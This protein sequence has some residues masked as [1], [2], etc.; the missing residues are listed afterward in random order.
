MTSSVVASTSASL[1]D[2]DAA[3][4][5]E[6]FRERADFTVSKN[7]QLLKVWYASHTLF[8][9]PFVFSPLTIMGLLLCRAK[10]EVTRHHL[11]EWMGPRPLEAVD[12]GSPRLQFTPQLSA[13][14]CEHQ[15]FACLTSASTR[16]W[17]PSGQKK[18][19]MSGI[20]IHSILTKNLY[21]VTASVL[22]KLI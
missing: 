17:R 2:I 9:L 21:F 18:I 15:L 5:Q 11:A 6:H 22:Q 14:K 10:R 1:V 8:S 20:L 16:P 4:E 13:L 19:V 7:G 12:L 3:V